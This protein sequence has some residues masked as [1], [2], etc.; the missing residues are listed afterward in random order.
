MNT[1]GLE[2]RS[3]I[4]LPASEPAPNPRSTIGYIFGIRGVLSLYIM[5][6]HLNNMIL[7]ARLGVVAPLYSALT[8]WLRVGDFRVCTFFVISGY[9]LTLPTT[10]TVEWQL[11]DGIRGFLARRSERLLLPYYIAFALSVVLYIAWRHVIGDP[12]GMRGTAVGIIAHLL[13]IHNLDPRTSLLINDTLWNVALEFQCYLLFAFVFLPIMRTYGPWAQ[14]LVAA[15]IGLGPHFLCHGFLDW[16]RPWFITLYSMGV[17]AA[18]LANRVHPDLTRVERGV[19]WGTLWLGTSIAGVI[20]VVASGIDTE[21]GAGWLQ[22]ILLGIAVSS[23]LIFMR[24]GSGGPPGILARPLVRF[25]ESP[26]LCRLGRFSYSTYL[27]HFPI[28]RLAVALTAL[29][30]TSIW[31]LSALCFLVYVPITLLLAYG[32][33]VCFELPLQTR[34]SPLRINTLTRSAPPA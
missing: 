5:C 17:T 27:I 26:L 34:K 10:K 31:Y 28:L 7:Q 24:T 18:A 4:V 33:H 16:T 14:L 15:A 21:Y 8:D 6:F 1:I 20:A 13:L 25:L 2:A 32:F 22:N 11:R 29:W 9:L 19:P 23:F 3:S 12:P 30:T